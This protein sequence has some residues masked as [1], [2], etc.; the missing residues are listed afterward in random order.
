MLIIIKMSNILRQE[1]EAKAT[2]ILEMEGVLFFVTNVAN[3][4]QVLICKI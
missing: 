3:R 1:V 2:Y 4:G